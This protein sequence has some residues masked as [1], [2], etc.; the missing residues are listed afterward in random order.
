MEKFITGSK[1]GLNEAFVIDE[2][3]KNSLI[4]KDKRSIELIKPFLIGREIKRY[5]VPVGGS[6]L[7]LIPRGW[8]RKKSNGA[9]D[10]WSWFSKNYPA[11]ATHLQQFAEK[12]EQ[13]YDKGEYWWELRACDY[14]DEFEKT[15]IVYPNICKQPEFT[16]EL[17]NSFTNQ[18]CFIIPIADKYLLGVLNS[19]LCYFLFR[20]TLPKLRGDFYEPSY[21]YFKDFPIRTI[22]FTDTTDKARHNNMVSLVERMLALHKQKPRT[23]QEQEMVKREIESTDRQIDNLVNE[24]YGLTEEDIRTVEEE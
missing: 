7:I 17:T 10:A 9:R 3:E 8:T 14:Y 2:T 22:N 23:P 19:S 1:T 12:A 21:V 11:I 18:K 4:A 5:S 24:L 6:Y 15:K 13:R 20:K 16:F